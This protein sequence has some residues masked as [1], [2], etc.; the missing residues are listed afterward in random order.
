MGKP[1]ARV[2][3]GKAKLTDEL[4]GTTSV[5]SATTN[6]PKPGRVVSDVAWRIR[7]ISSATAMP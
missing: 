7:P 2:M 5:P 4:N 3:N 6:T 1:N